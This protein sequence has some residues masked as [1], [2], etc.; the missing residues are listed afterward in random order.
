M[1]TRDHAINAT[2]DL[3]AELLYYGRKE[4]NELPR[5]AIENMLAN[6]EL[7]TYQIVDAFRD[8]LIEGLA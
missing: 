6:G 8:A 4:D 3:A 2:K 1:S 5:G 7:T